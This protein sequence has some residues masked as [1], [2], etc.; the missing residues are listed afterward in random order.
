TEVSLHGINTSRKAK[1]VTHVSGTKRHLSLKSD[2]QDRKFQPAR[3]FT[4]R[5]LPERF[6][7]CRRLSPVLPSVSNWRAQQIGC[8]RS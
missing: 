1:S 7:D 2:T 5:Q 3:S 8:C 6:G 4:S